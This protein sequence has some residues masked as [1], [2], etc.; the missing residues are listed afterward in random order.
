MEPMGEKE[1]IEMQVAVRRK[2][3]TSVGVDN[4]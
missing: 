4:N 1:P 2:M 3:M